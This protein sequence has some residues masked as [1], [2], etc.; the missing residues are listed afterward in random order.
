MDGGGRGHRRPTDTVTMTY[1]EL[2]AMVNDRLAKD[3]SSRARDVQALIVERD[4]LT[5]EV[6]RLREVLQ[7]RQA[8]DHS[9]L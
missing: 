3:R 5:V 8:N 2:N 4:R 6:N 7:Q 9:T 1:A